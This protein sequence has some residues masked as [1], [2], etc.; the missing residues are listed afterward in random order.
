MASKQGVGC[1][2]NVSD[3]RSELADLVKRKAE[4]SVSLYNIQ[5]PSIHMYCQCYHIQIVQTFVKLRP[6][7]NGLCPS[8]II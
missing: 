5:K 6:P 1:S 8:H 7:L 4:I 2:S 3:V